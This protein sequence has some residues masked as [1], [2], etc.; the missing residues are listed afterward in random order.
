MRDETEKRNF[1]LQSANLMLEEVLNN[2]QLDRVEQLSLLN[3]AR[4]YF[5]DLF[6]K[7]YK[8]T[9]LRRN[10][11]TIY[12]LKVSIDL[13]NPTDYKLSVEPLENLYNG[14]SLKPK[15]DITDSFI[16]LENVQKSKLINLPRRTSLIDIT[17][18]KRMKCC[19]EIL[20][21]PSQKRKLIINFY[22]KAFV[23]CT[24]SKIKSALYNPSPRDEISCKKIRLCE[25][26]KA[27]KHLSSTQ[28]PHHNVRAVKKLETH[29]PKKS[30][31]FEFI[32]MGLVF[33]EIKDRTHQE[34][35]I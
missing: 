33:S 1:V 17:P 27:L 31:R 30:S 28:K 9:E 35:L 5:I 18:L 26:L 10:I 8:I 7:G 6:R 25:R 12:E 32:R 14:L 11:Q 3:N 21:T 23:T 34:K 4:K 22:G 16:G 20:A 15:T 13:K 24:F 19:S 29:F 2:E